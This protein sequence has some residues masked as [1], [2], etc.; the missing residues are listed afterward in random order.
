MALPLLIDPLA[1]P[2]AGAPLRQAGFSLIE[3][4]MV[5]V[6]AGI[7]AAVALPRMSLLTGM[8]G[9]TF[10][11]ELRSTLQGVRKSAISARRYVC[12]TLSGNDFSVSLDAREPDTF[13]GAINC[14]QNMTL[15]VPGKACS[16][17]APEKICAPGGMTVS[18]LSGGMAFDPGGR[19]Y[20][21]NGTGLATF[22]INVIDGG[23]DAWPVT[24]EGETGLVH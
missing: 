8:N 15:P 5:L 23:A 24:I 22:V 3:L 2:L 10:R 13:T 12:V 17:P 11:D 21:L 4:I 6:L 14:T 18:G 16:T 19:P 20:A 9:P 7:M 1:A